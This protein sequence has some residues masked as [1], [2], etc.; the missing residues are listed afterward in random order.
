MAKGPTPLQEDLVQGEPAKIGRHVLER[1]QAARGEEV[2]GF[3]LPL[4]FALPGGQAGGGEGSIQGLVVDIQFRGRG[5]L[6]AALGAEQSGKVRRH[7]EV[8]RLASADEVEDHS[9]SPL[10]GKISPHERFQ[11]R[12]SWMKIIQEFPSLTCVFSHEMRSSSYIR[13]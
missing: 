10:G 4:L 11:L 6:Q 3:P 9:A 12:Q 7:L 1:L 13:I 2:D 5:S 8:A